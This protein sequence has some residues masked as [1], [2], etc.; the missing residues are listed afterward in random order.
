MYEAKLRF[1]TDTK[2]TIS[3]VFNEK[4]NI[5]E[6]NFFKGCERY[7][8]ITFAEYKDKK[9]L[10]N[11]IIN[12]IMQYYS[13]EQNAYSKNCIKWI[14]YKMKEVILEEINTNSLVIYTNELFDIAFQQYIRELTKK[15][16]KGEKSEN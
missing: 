5:Q 6:K 14:K 12:Y 1:Y 7:K 3:V 10:I 11:N 8:T 2:K 4:Q 15:E 9:N 16:K 13:K